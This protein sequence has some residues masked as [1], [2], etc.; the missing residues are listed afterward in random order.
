MSLLR[1]RNSVGTIIAFRTTNVRGEG[2]VVGK[3]DSVN[4]VVANSP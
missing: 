4:V 3:P 2:I 1:D